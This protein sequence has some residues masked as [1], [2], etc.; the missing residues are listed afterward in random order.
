MYEMSGSAR[1]V[2]RFC[3]LQARE[4]RIVSFSVMLWISSLCL[5]LS[6]CI[7]LILVDQ[8]VSVNMECARKGMATAIVSCSQGW[9]RCMQQ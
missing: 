4:H 7:Y 2:E 9:V 8:I 5:D 3:G 1:F 6:A